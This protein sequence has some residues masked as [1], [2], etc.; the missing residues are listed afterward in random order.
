MNL[1]NYA[2]TEWRTI[3]AS[4]KD[5]NTAFLPDQ[6][7]LKFCPTLCHLPAYIRCRSPSSAWAFAH[8]SKWG[9]LTPTGK[10]DEKLKSENVLN[11]EFFKNRG[12]VKW[13]EWWLKIFF[14]SGG[15]GALTPNQ[16]PTDDHASCPLYQLSFWTSSDVHNGPKKVGHRLMTIL[17]SNVNRF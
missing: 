12:G 17:L 7:V 16:N 14:A 3:Y 6:S 8:R 15:K 10:M 1:E 13:Y 11:R 9:Q 4:Y 2:G 5:V